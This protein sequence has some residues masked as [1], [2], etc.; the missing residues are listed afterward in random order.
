MSWV[1]ALSITGAGLLCLGV[2]A[3]HGWIRLAERGGSAATGMGLILMSLALFARSYFVT[4]YRWWNFTVGVIGLM[5]GAAGLLDAAG[6]AA[7][8]L[9]RAVNLGR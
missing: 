3:G 9:L 1:N 4:R 7:A 8:P 5:G 2:A 6:V